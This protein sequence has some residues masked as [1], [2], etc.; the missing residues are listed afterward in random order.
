MAS[1]TKQDVIGWSV[2]FPYILKDRPEILE[3]HG[4]GLHAESAF[5]AIAVGVVVLAEQPFD[6]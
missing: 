4:A 5:T 6:P 1:T 2:V 3:Y